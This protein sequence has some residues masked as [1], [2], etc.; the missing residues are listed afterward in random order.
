MKQYQDLMRLLLDAPFKG[1]RT[2]TGTYSIFGHQMRF[3]LQKGFPL[4]TTKKVP[5]HLIVKEL[6]WFLEG[7]TNAHDLAAQGCHIWDEWALETGELGPIYGKQWR[8]WSAPNMTAIDEKLEKIDKLIQEIRSEQDSDFRRDDAA[9]ARKLLLE[10]R[11][12]DSTRTIDQIREVIHTI[13]TKPH[14]RRLIVSAWNPVDMPDESVSPQEN[15]AEGRMALAACHT[16]F[17]FYVSDMTENERKAHLARQDD[18]FWELLRTARINSDD[19]ASVPESD[20]LKRSADDSQW[21]YKDAYATFE[22]YVEEN[23]PKKKLSCQLY[24]RSADAFLGV[25]FNI[26]S[27]A[28]L[29]HMIAQ[30]CDLAVG[31][32]IWTGG[33][34]HIYSNH[35]EQTKVLISREPKTLPTLKLNPEIKDI[36]AFALDDIELVDYQSHS[37]IKGKVSV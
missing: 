28:L 24:Q 9:A 30:V 26:A 23:A 37:A 18:K 8:S 4:V 10:I 35:V 22:S 17:Q 33:D 36:D 5:F 11:E 1:D 29:T 7:N 13:K 14:S 3:D 32:F 12:H 20:R 19:L 2:G 25:P 27:Y 16:L 31:D 34:C 21:Y 6:L 15:V